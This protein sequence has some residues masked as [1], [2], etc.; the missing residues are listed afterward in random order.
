MMLT[1]K[2]L[3]VTRPG[4]GYFLWVR[5]DRALTDAE[6]A[7]LAERGVR[8]LAGKRTCP[9]TYLGTASERQDFYRACFRIS[10]AFYTSEKLLLACKTI[11][12]LFK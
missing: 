11:C 9:H 4:G 3:K 12:E 6:Y 1:G 10:I 5:A 8:V 7:S 2:I